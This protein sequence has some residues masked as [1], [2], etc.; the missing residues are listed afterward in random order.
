MTIPYIPDPEAIGRKRFPDDK[1]FRRTLYESSIATLAEML[2]LIAS[3]YP[4]DGSTNFS[5][6]YRIVAREIA[7]LKYSNDTIN[8]NKQYTLTQVQYLQQ[9]LGERLYLGSRIAPTGYTD[10][11]YRNYLLA[12]KNA[13]LKGSLK[14]NIETIAS[15]LPAKQLK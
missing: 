14:S 3:N 2:D 12:I 11:S 1:G 8:N 5:I 9:I 10:E 13:Y 6:F 15:N 7:R 4:K